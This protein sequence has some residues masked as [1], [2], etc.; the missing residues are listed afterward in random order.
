MSFFTKKK[1]I[2]GVLLLLPVIFIL[3]ATRGGEQKGTD[4]ISQDLM[5]QPAPTEKS[6]TVPTGQ[7]GKLG[8]AVQAGVPDVFTTQ[9]IISLLKEAQAQVFHGCCLA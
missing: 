7:A 8:M 6:P 3:A 5:T 4:D 9:K 2:I 1:V